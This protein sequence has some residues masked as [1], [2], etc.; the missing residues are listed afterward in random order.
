MVLPLHR[1]QK[2][3]VWFGELTRHV[4]QDIASFAERIETSQV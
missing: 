1:P 3:L 2:A 4:S